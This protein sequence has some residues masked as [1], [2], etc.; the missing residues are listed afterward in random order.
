MCSLCFRCADNP[1]ST[2]PCSNDGYC[3]ADEGAVVGGAFKCECRKEF[4]GRLCDK[5]RNE[6][7]P[8]PCLNRG[9]CHLKYQGFHCQCKDGFFGRVC[10]QGTAD[11][12]RFKKR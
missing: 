5:P 7:H 12:P 4:T 2:Q 8:N 3:S 10:E 11:E 9:K 6:C 1:C